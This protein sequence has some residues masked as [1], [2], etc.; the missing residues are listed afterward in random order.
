[1]LVRGGESAGGAGHLLGRL[2]MH[3]VAHQRCEVYLVRPDLRRARAHRFLIDNGRSLHH[4]E[5]FVVLLL[6]GRFEVARFRR[7]LLS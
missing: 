2:G 3:A 4:V 6:I 5:D 7:G 1:M